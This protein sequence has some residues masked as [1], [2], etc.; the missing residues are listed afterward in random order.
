MQERA[1]KAVEDAKD[2]VRIYL[3]ASPEVLYQRITGDVRSSETRP[4]LTNLGGGLDEVA[5]MLQLRGPTYETVADVILEISDMN[6]Q[7]VTDA[8]LK[9]F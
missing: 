8:V 4:N 1:R 3:K 6:L 7:Q 2:T 5:H 9:A